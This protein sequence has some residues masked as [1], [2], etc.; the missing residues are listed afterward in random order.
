MHRYLNYGP[1]NLSLPEDDFAND[2]DNCIWISMGDAFEM[3]DMDRSLKLR[4]YYL[5]F[6]WRSVL[7]GTIPIAIVG[8][9][10]MGLFPI[11]QSIIGM[12]ITI[13][14]FTVALYLSHKQIFFNQLRRFLDMI[15]YQSVKY[16]KKEVKRQIKLKWM[17]K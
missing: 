8:V 13:F 10:L 2:P 1:K 6:I 16:K 15:I 3:G 17:I 9:F 7:G 12:L 14:T 4:D 5:G 11:Y